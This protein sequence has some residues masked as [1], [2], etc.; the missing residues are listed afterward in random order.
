MTLSP[1]FITILI[2]CPT[3]PRGVQEPFS[4]LRAGRTVL[5]LPFLLAVLLVP[6]VPAFAQ[7]DFTGV[8]NGNTNSEDGPERAAGP[9]LVEFLGLPINDQARQ[10]G[11]AYRPGRLSLPEHQCQVHASHYI[12][13][14]PF[15]A[16]IWEERDP[17][18]H[19][20]IAIHEAISTYE[21]KRTI[22]MDGRPHPSPNAAHT[23]MGFSTGV[24][25]GNM[26]TV[27]TT[28]IKQ[29]WHRRENLPSSDE[30]TMIEHWVRNGNVWTHISVTEDPIF[31]AEPLIKSEDLTLN[32][33]P[34]F[35]PFWP[36]ESIE[37]GERPRGQVPHYLPGTNP[38]VA[39]YAAIHKLPQEV[40]LGGPE[41]MYP[42]YR[43]RMKTL[44]VA[45]FEEKAP[46]TVGP[47][48]TPAAPAGGRGAA[49]PAGGRGG[50]AGRGG[51]GN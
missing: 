6:S 5:V 36:C 22:W 30:V 44:P 23:W 11:L 4:M 49:P 12:H 18:T 24:W 50:G 9:S 27:T 34:N 16:R 48:S 26:L 51:G 3:D 43:T 17:V 35:N 46:P 8:W 47:S 31:L 1:E 13:R 32:P 38:W 2:R 25:Q 15:A 37:E 40:T 20:L 28:H 41:Q 21:Q 39:E 19:Q 33:S 42:E 10:W 29:A 14:G 7:V 45:V